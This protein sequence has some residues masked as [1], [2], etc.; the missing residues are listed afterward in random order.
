MLTV[1]RG[2]EQDSA[3]VGELHRAGGAD[4]ERLTELIFELANAATHRG[5]SER[6]RLRCR[7]EVEPLGHFHEATKRIQ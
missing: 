7:A 2:R 5:R 6:Y 1:F 3:C 4:E